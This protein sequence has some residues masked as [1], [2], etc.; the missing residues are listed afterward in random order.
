[1]SFPSPAI[2]ETPSF[3]L[4]VPQTKN[5][6]DCT[7]IT[8]LLSFSCSLS[9]SL[10]PSLL[11]RDRRRSALL[12]QVRFLLLF[13]FRRGWFLLLLLSRKQ[14][15]IAEHRIQNDHILRVK[16][17]QL[18]VPKIIRHEHTRAVFRVIPPPTHHARSPLLLLSSLTMPAVHGNHLLLNK[19]APPF[20]LLH[21]LRHFQRQLHVHLHQ[22]QRIARVNV[23]CHS[24]WQRI[25][26]SRAAI[27]IRVRVRCSSRL[28]RRWWRRR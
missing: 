6:K 14:Q 26:A 7:I 4:K 12:F 10:W 16:V 8:K 1:M 27:R 28:L 5:P 2:P 13:G 23:R 24:S 19:H 11:R 9:L 15:V 17:Q 18:D 25:T 21:V 3:S 22:P 20:Q